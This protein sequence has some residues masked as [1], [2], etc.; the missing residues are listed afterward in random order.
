MNKISLGTLKNILTPK[1]MKNITGGSTFFV[2]CAGGAS[3]P[4]EAGSCN[5]VEEFLT[6]HYPNCDWQAIL[7]PGC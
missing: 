2:A 1:E 4:V 6:Q 3:F 5:E 7:G